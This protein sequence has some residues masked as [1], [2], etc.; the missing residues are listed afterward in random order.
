[1]KFHAIIKGLNGEFKFDSPENLK[2][3]YNACPIV[4]EIFLR[5]SR[6]GKSK[7]YRLIKKSKKYRIK[8]HDERLE[9]AVSQIENFIWSQ[10][11]GEK[12]ESMISDYANSFVTLIRKSQNKQ[13]NIVVECLNLK[14]KKKD[15]EV[16]CLN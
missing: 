14:S 12:Y 7:K 8:H 4:E 6:N 10:L 15:I 13:K 5:K 16:R 2:K 11:S 9:K 3:I 1:M